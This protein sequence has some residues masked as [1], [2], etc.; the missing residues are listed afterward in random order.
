MLLSV[1]RGGVIGLIAAPRVG[2]AGVASAVIF[3]DIEPYRGGLSVM[4]G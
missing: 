3:S 2:W 4:R 1:R